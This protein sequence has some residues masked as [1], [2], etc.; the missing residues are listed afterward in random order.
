MAIQQQIHAAIACAAQC[1]IGLARYVLATLGLE[2]VQ[3]SRAY[4]LSGTQGVFVVIIIGRIILRKDLDHR[5]S[6][7]IENGYCQFPSLNTL[8]H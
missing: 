6:S 1:F 5:V 7:T 2:C 3:L 8:L 4:I